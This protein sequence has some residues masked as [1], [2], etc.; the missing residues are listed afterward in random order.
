MDEDMAAA[1][2]REKVFQGF[3][4]LFDFLTAY[5]R[6]HPVHIDDEIFSFGRD[7]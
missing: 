7:F 1:K 3:G 5:G 6:H 4:G 2:A